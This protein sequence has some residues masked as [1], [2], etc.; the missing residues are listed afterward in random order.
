[1]QPATSKLEVTVAIAMIV[2]ARSGTGKKQQRPANRRSAGRQ[3]V[4]C[5][6]KCRQMLVELDHVRG[7]SYRLGARTFRA[8]SDFVLDYLTFTEFLDS[9]S[10][11]RR[12]MEEQVAPIPFDEPKTSIRNQPLD[13]TLWHCCSPM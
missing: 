10:L 2:L 11:D 5:H 3:L 13:F 12:V 1:M 9:R 6:R 8:T 7:D 4:I